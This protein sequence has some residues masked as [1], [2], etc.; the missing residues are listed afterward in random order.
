MGGRGPAPRPSSTRSVSGARSYDPTPGEPLPLPKPP[1]GGWH[2]RSKVAWVETTSAG[3]VTH[4][5][6]SD[7]V[8]AETWLRLFDRL[9]RAVDDREST[10]ASLR[11]LSAEVRALA[12]RLGMSP[13]GRAALRWQASEGRRGGLTVVPTGAVSDGDLERARVRVAERR[14]RDAI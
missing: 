4:W 3:F 12:D 14:D 11:T 9:Q 7:L 1:R 5:L 6:P 8:L 2:P 13:Q 10:P